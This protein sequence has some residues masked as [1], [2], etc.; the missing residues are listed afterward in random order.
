MALC[1]IIL[2]HIILY[3][4]LYCSVLYD[5]IL[6]YIIMYFVIRYYIM[7]SLQLAVGGGR[8]A[9][10]NGPGGPAGSGPREAPEAPLI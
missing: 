6:Y 4:T 2:Y 9:R 10:G 3:Y 8:Q 1:Y 5:I 7:L